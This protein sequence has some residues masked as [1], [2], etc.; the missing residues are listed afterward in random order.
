M[1]ITSRL[2]YQDYQFQAQT[3]QGVWRWT[4]RMDVSGAF[5]QYEVRDIFTPFGLLRD[6]VPIPGDVIDQMAASIGELQQSFPPALQVDPLVLNFTL[7]EG[8][9]FG[10]GQTIQVTNAGV[11]GSLLNLSVSSSASYVSASPTTLGSLALN[12]SGV[13]TVLVD[14]THLLAS[15]SPYA[16]SVTLQDP[17]ATNSPQAVSVNVV[18]RPKATIVLGPPALIFNVIKPPSGPF[19][20]IPV[21]SFV[22][23]NTGPIGSVLQYLVQKLTGC[24]T[25]I[26]NINPFTGT[27]PGGGAT[28]VTVT[29]APDA[30][31]PIGTY[32]ETLR[33]SGYS[34]NFYQDITVQLNVT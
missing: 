32:N 23:Q 7:D 4:T 6:R 17:T 12:E 34:S 8:R 13:L 29:V 18:V 19:P 33:V 22:I 30:S 31:L 9:G 15:G 11:F 25:W 24:G 27:I 20:P 21:Q 3:P 28:N 16:A 26:T 1:P 2:Q 10:E 5:P 14:S